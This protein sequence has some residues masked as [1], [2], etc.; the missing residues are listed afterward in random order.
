[1][2]SLQIFIMICFSSVYLSI[3]FCNNKRHRRY[4]SIN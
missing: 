3:I 2:R 4:P 1:M